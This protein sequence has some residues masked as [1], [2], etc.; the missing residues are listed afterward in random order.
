MQRSIT[1][2][3]VA[4]LLAFAG[5]SGSDGRREIIGTVTLDGQPLASGLINFRPAE[6]T[7]ANS[8]GGTITEGRFRLP[9]AKGLMPG[10]YVVRVQAFQKSGRKVN[11]PQMGEID[12]MVPIRFNETGTLKATI[13]DGGENQLEFALTAAK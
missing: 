13:A 6:G 11:D 8:S 1:L 5:C 10:E 7:K 3:L 12:E 4:C 2:V 9:A